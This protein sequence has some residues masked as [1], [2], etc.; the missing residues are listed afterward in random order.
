MNPV[1]LTAKNSL[2][3]HDILN[4]TH[5][6]RIALTP[7]YDSMMLNTPMRLHFEIRAVQ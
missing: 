2:K 3:N 1:V 4:L 7:E 6:P 5:V